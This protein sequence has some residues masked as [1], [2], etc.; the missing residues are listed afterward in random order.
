M[1][2]E[3]F[4]RRI[5]APF[6]GVLQVVRVGHGEAES[7][8]GISWVLYVAHPD[9]LAHSG[10]SEVRFGTWS[11]VEG[12]RRAAVRGTAAGG[13]I[14]AIGEPLIAAL[15][16]CAA[17]APFAL[18]DSRE[19]WLV[20]HQSGAPLVLI[21]TRLPDESLSAV[22]TARWLPGCAAQAEFA[23]LDRLEAAV[24]MRGGPRPGARWFLRDRGGD[25][26]GADGER[27]PATAFPRLLLTTAWPDQRLCLLAESFIAWWAPALLQLQ[28][29]DDSERADLER[30]AVRR[31]PVVERLFRLYPKIIDQQLLRVIR[32][33]ARMQASKGE[34]G[35]YQEPFL[36]SDESV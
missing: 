33:Q 22:E 18:A 16:Q 26:L 24:K 1:T 9:I 10:L 28:H 19:C 32:V 31:A 14:E 34:G 15:E 35:C 25:A 11:A 7:T 17:D 3:C 12:L 2:V 20:D 36:W 21:D 13:L 23:G 8:D 30:S 5:M 6:Q 4:A 29:L 27:L